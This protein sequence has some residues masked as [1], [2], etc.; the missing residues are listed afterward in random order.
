MAEA[1][2]VLERFDQ[3]A[4]WHRGDQRAPHKPLLILYALGRWYRRER[5]D[6][7]FSDV[8]RDLAKLLKEFGPS[9][10][11]QHPEYPFW[12]LRADGVW[13]VHAPSDIALRRGNTDALKSDLLARDIHAGF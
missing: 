3:L 13:T 1:T 10:R 8:N 12:R 2:T 5:N 7:P 9:R 6:I 4:I 11:S